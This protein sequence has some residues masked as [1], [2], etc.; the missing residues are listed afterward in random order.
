MSQQLSKEEIAQRKKDVRANAELQWRLSQPM[1]TFVLG[2]LALSLCKINP[3]KGQF[4][5]I[6]P[7]VM[8]YIIYMN[9]LLT[10]RAWVG[11]GTITSLYGFHAMVLLLI[12][13]FNLVQHRKGRLFKQPPREIMP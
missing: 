10:L 11:Q 8:L 5:H 12:V 2:L 1:A 9:T 3:R 7:A 4:S 13:L 6:I